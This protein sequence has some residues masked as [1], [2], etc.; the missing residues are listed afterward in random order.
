MARQERRDAILSY[1]HRNTIPPPMRRLERA[2][3]TVLEWP[4]LKL[5]RLI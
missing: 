5:R 2:V 4:L 3:R 1:L